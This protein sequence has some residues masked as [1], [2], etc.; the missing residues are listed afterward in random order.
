[1]HTSRLARAR[2]VTTAFN[3]AWVE[4]V[5]DSSTEAPLPDCSPLPFPAALSPNNAMTD[6]SHPTPT[7]MPE[8]SDEEGE[9][10]NEDEQ[11]PQTTAA[12]STDAKPKAKSR[13]PSPI[14]QAVSHCRKPLPSPI[15]QSTPRP[16]S[17]DAK[18]KAKSRLPSPIRQAVSHCRKPLP[19]P[20]RQ[21]TPRPRP[22]SK[23]LL[24]LQVRVQSS[25]V[26]NLERSVHILQ[27]RI[28]SL[29]ISLGELQ[30]YVYNS[31]RTTSA[32]DDIKSIDTLDI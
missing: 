14:R 31:P 16:S 21:S 7:Q 30:A 8:P 20:I 12:S 24:K 9:K 13:L 1:M 26:R 15:R 32:F 19:S 6:R 27:D 25:R 2:V 28:T 3:G 4:L 17:T 22:A 10:T 29:E 5:S 11:P 23:A 18:P